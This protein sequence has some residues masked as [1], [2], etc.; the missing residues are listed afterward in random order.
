[1]GRFKTS[2]LGLRVRLTIPDLA[3]PYLDLM[4][5]QSVGSAIRE[6]LRSAGRPAA[7]ALKS[8]MQGE[9][10][11]SEQS[12]GASERAIGVKYGRSKS[13]KDNFY[14]I[15]G[16]LTN[17]IEFH[18]SKIPDG[19]ITKLRRGRKQR[20]A[21]LFAK[22]LTVQKN[23]IVKSKQVFSRYRDKQRINKSGGKPF[24]RFPRKYFHLINK[25]FDHYRGGRTRA[26]MFLQKLK[27]S[28][29]NSMQEIFEERLINLIIPTMKK[30]IIRK[31]KN[32]LK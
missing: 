16:T 30:E 2:H 31:W 7:T 8:I 29:G 10:R 11:V 26:Y 20:G 23:K 19:Q 27:A 1:M 9:L 28:L 32:V 18:S 3:L 14:I 12:T 21:G 5:N 17:K 6:A 15:V 22:Q 4:D 13:N 24:K 25:G